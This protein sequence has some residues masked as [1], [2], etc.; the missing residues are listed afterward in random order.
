M[1]LVTRAQW[2]ARPATA[3]PPTI[4]PSTTTGHWEG[5]SLW[6]GVIGPHSSCAPKV[7]AIQAYHMDHQGWTDIAYNGLGCPHGYVFE[8]RGPGRRSAANGT[9]TANGASHAL[10]YLGGEGDPFTDAG[11][12]AML[13]GAAWLGTPLD[14][15]H[16]D[17]FQ[18]ACCGSVICGWI[19]AGHPAP[20][21]IPME[22]DDMTPG[23]CRDR[24][25]RKWFFVVGDDRA[26]YAKV[27]GGSYDRLGGVFT[28]GVQALCEAS[29]DVSINGL[30]VVTG[31]ALDGQLQQ[32]RIYTD[33][34]PTPPPPGGN[35]QFDLLGGHIFP[36]A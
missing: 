26:L 31:R 24:L 12:A 4:T 3:T 34:G 2:G 23:Q 6:G 36:P 11:K 32:C 27:D 16:S 13:D 30:I 9:N 33:G 5:P 14:K 17:W 20:G 25:G 1:K 21:P 10:C 28:S 22:D 35:V 15:C 18:T 29:S 7:R 8:G 19:K